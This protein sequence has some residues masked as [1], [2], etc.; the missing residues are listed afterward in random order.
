MRVK[1]KISI[2]GLIVLVAASMGVNAQMNS[3]TVTDGANFADSVTGKM[4]AMTTQ[5]ETH[6]AKAL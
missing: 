2:I 1:N 4:P 5:E 6:I 3:A